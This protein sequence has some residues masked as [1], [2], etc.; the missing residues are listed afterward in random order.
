[1]DHNIGRNP[2]AVAPQRLARFIW[3]ELHTDTLPAGADSRP[4]L[5]SGRLL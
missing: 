5:S 4:A 2:A 1:L 3:P